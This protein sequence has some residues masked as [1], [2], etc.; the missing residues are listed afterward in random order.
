MSQKS[1]RRFILIVLAVVFVAI[2]AIFF[3]RHINKSTTNNKA[4]TINYSNLPAIGNLNA[5]NKILAVEDLK[6]HG[7]MVYNN[8]IYPQLKKELIDSGKSSY[9]VLLVS[10]LPGSEPA[11]NVA[12]CLNAQNPDYSHRLS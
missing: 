8:L 6:C 1:N 4:Q 10:F 11:A 12:Y 3:F 7:C 5:P 9:H 2:L